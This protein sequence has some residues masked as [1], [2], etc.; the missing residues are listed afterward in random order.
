MS[1]IKP[2][3]PQIGFEKTVNRDL[4][5]TDSL[6]HRVVRGG[7]WVFA[8]RI[9][10]RGLGFIRTIML[11]RLLAPAD[12]GLLG[13]A[14][15]AI[16]TL[17]SFSQTGFQAALI[18]KKEDVE[19]YLDTA[20]TV[21]AIRGIL[22]FLILYFTAPIIAKFF[23]SSQAT[24]VIK[25]IAVSTLLSG[26]RNIGIL[27]F[28]RELEFNKQFVYSLSATLT[29]LTVSISLAFILRNV[30][31]LVFGGLA[32]NF[33]RLFLSYIL[34]PY[35]PRIRV[36]PGEFNELLGFGRWILGSSILIFLIT[37]GDDIFVGKMLGVTALGLYQMAYLISNLPATEITHVISQVTFPAYSKLKGDMPKLK[38][39]Y[40]K[41]LQLTAFISIP[42]AGGIFILAPEFTKIFLG[43]QWMPMVSAMQLLALAG[44]LRSIT[45]TMSP[46]FSAVKRP[47]IGTK[48]QAIRLFFLAVLIYPLTIRWGLLGASF[49]VFLSI[50]MV[51]F[52]FSFMVIRITRCSVQKFIK[53]I[54]LPLTNALIMV[55]II[56]YLKS[57]IR[58]INVP[59]FILLILVGTISYFFT[60]YLFDKFFNYDMQKL[61]KENLTFWKY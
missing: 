28:Q 36:E 10:N 55:A 23:N 32:A 11:A 6:S 52:V 20:W 24:L 59:Q 29:D 1:L 25:V 18:Q 41:V 47:D 14:M 53:I 34:H 31:A 48:H 44:L 40:L 54:I 38:E 51:S 5:H 7:I 15:L 60:A 42:L 45:S 39:A 13:I 22:L 4:E 16:A 49:A 27:F 17:E 35:R 58:P 2:I 12:F 37:Q 30:W 9:T 61:F 26:F 43:D 8:L 21:S 33:I 57:I 50:L 46:V 19:S 56:I 3:L